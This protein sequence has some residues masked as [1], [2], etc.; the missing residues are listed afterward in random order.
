MTV[1][2]VALETREADAQACV[3]FWALLGYSPVEPPASLRDRALWVERDGRQIHFMYADEP[4]VPSDGHVALIDRELDAT[5]ER[6]QAAGIE[7][8]ERSQYWGARRVLVDD[9]AGHVVELMA[10]PPG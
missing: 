8:R 2:H 3:E 10:A 7:V 4:V 6:L 1:H 9:P 5:V